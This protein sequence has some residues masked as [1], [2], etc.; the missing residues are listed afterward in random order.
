M[1]A[2]IERDPFAAFPDEGAQLDAVFGPLAPPATPAPNAHEL[3]QREWSAKDTLASYADVTPLDQEWLWEGY[4]PFGKVTLIA[5]DSGIGKGTVLC[6]LVARVSTGDVMP[7]GSAGNPAGHVI[8]ITPED[9]PRTCTVHRLRTH[10]ADLAMV[11]DLTLV[12][13]NVFAIQEDIGALRQLI[14][15][16]GGAALVI[17]DPISAVTLVGLTSDVPV[18]R[19]VIGPLEAV[20]RETGAAIVVVGHLTKSGV[21]EAAKNSG[22]AKDGMGGS[23]GLTSTVRIML[24]VTRDDSDPR[25]R[26]IRV[27]KS[28]G[29]D[30]KATPVVRYVIS[31]SPPKV[32]WLTSLDDGPE[33]A[34]SQEKAVLGAIRRLARKD[35]KPTHHGR[36]I[37]VEAGVEYDSARMALSRLKAKGEVASPDRGLFAEVAAELASISAEVEAISSGDWARKGQGWAEAPIGGTQ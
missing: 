13:G 10:G 31:G 24:S 1:T 8:M 27:V 29:T 25:I 12:G 17:I 21:K 26:S 33:Q 6:D 18:R 3:A 4:I 19:K 34:G 20:A 23:K 14:T 35:G 37:A 11:H 32:E 36:E 9:D 16:C 22:A 5:G 15:S 7:D 2:A 30:D 28:N